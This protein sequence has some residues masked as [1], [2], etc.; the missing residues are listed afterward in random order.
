MSQAVHTPT[1]LGHLRVL[2]LSRVLA[3]PWAAQVLGDLGAEVV[4][5]ERPDSGDDTRHWGPPFLRA[6]SGEEAEAAYF[7]ACNRNKRSLAVDFSQPEGADLIRRL[8][9]EF[10]VVIENF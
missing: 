10:D 2:D 1:A 5:V 4:K 8:V 3:G 7:T 9:P 6:A